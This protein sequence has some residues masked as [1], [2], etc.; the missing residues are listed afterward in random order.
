M[1]D[2]TT[3]VAQAVH[4]SGIV[5]GLCTVWCPHTTAAIRVNVLAG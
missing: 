2:I 3:Q 4:E 5:S 1:I